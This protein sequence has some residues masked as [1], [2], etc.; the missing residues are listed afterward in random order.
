MFTTQVLRKE[1]GE[2][3]DFFNTF[4]WNKNFHPGWFQATNM[5]LLKVDLWREP[6]KARGS[7][8]LPGVH[9]HLTNMVSGLGIIFLKASQEILMCVQQ[10]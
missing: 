5:I 3:S 2:K 6:P 9:S 8:P 1:E 10:G 7:W 4:P